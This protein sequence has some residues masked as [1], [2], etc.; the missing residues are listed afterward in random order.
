LGLSS[1]QTSEKPHIK[2]SPDKTTP[3]PTKTPN[4]TPTPQTTKAPNKTSTPQLTKAPSETPTP[5]PTKTPDK[6]P[7]PQPTKKTSDKT[8]ARPDDTKKND[9]TQPLERFFS[10]YSEF[11]YQPTRSPVTEFNRL[12]KEYGWER[13]LENARQAFKLT[14]KKWPDHTEKNGVNQ[15]LKRFFSRYSEFQYQP[16]SLPE[17]EFDRLCKE[18]GWEKKFEDARRKFNLAMKKEFDAL[19]GSDEEDIKNWY[20]LCHVLRIDPAPDTLKECRKVSS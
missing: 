10:Q 6:T 5:Q 1:D 9:V 18:Y 4:K 16:A 7:T 19:Y 12:R 15:P 20:K 11:Q 8:S 13:N 14:M 17:S 2:K 3:Q